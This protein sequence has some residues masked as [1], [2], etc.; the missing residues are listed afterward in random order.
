MPTRPLPAKH[1]LA[2]VAVM[3]VTYCKTFYIYASSG[4][5]SLHQIHPIHLILHMMIFLMNI[6]PGC[7]TL[8]LLGMII[9]YTENS[10]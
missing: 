8:G 5:S 4:V 2:S 7:H 9:Q 1:E 3:L 10:D 6:E